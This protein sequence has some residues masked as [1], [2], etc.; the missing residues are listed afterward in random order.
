[1]ILCIG[2]ASTNYVQRGKTCALSASRPDCKE[3][4]V[5]SL[6]YKD[7]KIKIFLGMRVLNF[8]QP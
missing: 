4:A 8:Q 2:L 5:W 3:F 6:I 7:K 1:M